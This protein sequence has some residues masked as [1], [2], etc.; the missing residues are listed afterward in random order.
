M[1]RLDVLLKELMERYDY[2][3]SQQKTLDIS[4]R[5]LEL[6]DVIVRVQ[7]LLIEELTEN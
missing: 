7:K 1:N 2:L 3:K 4:I 5:I 6:Q